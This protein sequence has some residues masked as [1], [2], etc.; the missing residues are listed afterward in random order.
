LKVLLLFSSLQE[1]FQE[2]QNATNGILMAMIIIETQGQPTSRDE[3]NVSTKDAI[4]F[5]KDAD[6]V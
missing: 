3:H 1:S 5:I 6:P 4:K 2:A